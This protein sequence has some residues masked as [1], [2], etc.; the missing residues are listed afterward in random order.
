MRL[1]EQHCDLDKPTAYREKTKNCQIGGK[2]FLYTY[3]PLGYLRLPLEILARRSIPTRCGARDFIFHPD[4]TYQQ[5]YER[6][7]KQY[8]EESIADPANF[9]L[10]ELL[11]VL[12]P[13]MPR[14][15]P[16]SDDPEID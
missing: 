10:G 3:K 11:T 16:D 6:V 14:P 8:I 5:E 9:K 4:K 2:Q 13:P 12:P 15:E 1:I 7:L